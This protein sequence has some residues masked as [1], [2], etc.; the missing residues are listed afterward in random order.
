MA[1]LSFCLPLCRSV[2]LRGDL[3]IRYSGWQVV[4]MKLGFEM[5][6]IW[7]SW[8]FGWYLSCKIAGRLGCEAALATQGY[9]AREKEAQRI[10]VMDVFPKER[11][12]ICVSAA[13]RLSLTKSQNWSIE[14]VKWELLVVPDEQFQWRDRDSGLI[15]LK[16]ECKAR[17]WDSGQIVC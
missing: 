4:Y 11:V 2:L 10:L 1:P 13:G 16:M 9:W 17:K 7:G 15:E 5:I 12:I 14:F 6:E 8:P 3:P